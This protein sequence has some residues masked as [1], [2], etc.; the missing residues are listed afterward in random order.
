MITAKET[1]LAKLKKLLNT[2]YLEDVT[3]TPKDKHYSA[4]LGVKFEDNSA[5]AIVFTF[6]NSILTDVDYAMLF[7]PNGKQ[8]EINEEI[9]HNDE[10][11]DVEDCVRFLKDDF[12]RFGDKPEFVSVDVL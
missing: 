4:I 5:I 6:K 7:T 8:K 12:K 10:G 11:V 1:D 3:N 9:Y 2:K